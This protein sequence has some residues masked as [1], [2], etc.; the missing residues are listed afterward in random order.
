MANIDICKNC[1]LFN[2]HK[3]MVN[4]SYICN[5]HGYTTIKMIG[6]GAYGKVYLAQK[7]FAIK[8]IAFK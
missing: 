8:K 1:K 2:E 3:Q 7:N 5:F 4:G 6:S